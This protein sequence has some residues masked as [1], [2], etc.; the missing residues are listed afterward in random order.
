MIRLDTKS[1]E[2]CTCIEI[3]VAMLYYHSVLYYH[4]WV[5]IR[6]SNFM[7]LVEDYVED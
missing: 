7:F 4:I 3:P 6:I 1:M 2:H 5:K